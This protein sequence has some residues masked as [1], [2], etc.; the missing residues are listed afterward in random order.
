MCDCSARCP[1]RVT[2]SVSTGQYG[3][4]VSVTRRWVTTFAVCV[5]CIVV[6]LAWFVM[7]YFSTHTCRHLM[8]VAYRMRVLIIEQANCSAYSCCQTCNPDRDMPICRLMLYWCCIFEYQGCAA[9]ESL[10]Q[11]TSP[12]ERQC[13][14]VHN[15][16]WMGANHWLTLAQSKVTLHQ[17]HK[18][19]QI[20][21]L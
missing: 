8:C 15:H 2:W 19:V 11:F 20:L 16:S 4:I 14:A 9:I 7:T 12:Y 17:S 10:L 6:R 3:H 5:G 21:S 1:S 13:T 18:T